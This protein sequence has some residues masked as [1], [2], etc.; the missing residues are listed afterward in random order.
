MAESR[1]VR[2]EKSHREAIKDMVDARGIADNGN[3][4][5]KQLL[6]AGMREYG[7]RNGAENGDTTLKRLTAEFARAFTWI[8]I[9]WL[10]LTMLLPVGFR[11]GAAFAFF[12]A[13]GCFAVYVA[14]DRR[15]P[16]VSKWIMGAF[17]GEK[18]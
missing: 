15:E 18:A 6:D 13:L 11:L 9:A 7:Y 3:E 10:T 2:L 12:A 14:L 16:R 1:G 4:A 17:G 5:I 8:G